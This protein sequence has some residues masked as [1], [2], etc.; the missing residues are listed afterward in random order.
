MA[1]RRSCA[2][3]WETA[4]VAL[5]ALLAPAR[6]KLTR[7]PPAELLRLR[8]PVKHD[9]AAR[10]GD[11]IAGASAAQV[12]A[13]TR[14]CNCEA[15]ACE[16]RG[17]L[18]AGLRGRH[19][20]ASAAHLFDRFAW[21]LTAA[22]AAARTDGSTLPSCATAAATPPTDASGPVPERRRLPAPPPRLFRPPVRRATDGM[23]AVSGEQGVP[24]LRSGGTVPTGANSDWPPAGHQA[25]SRTTHEGTE[26]QRSRSTAVSDWCSHGSGRSSPC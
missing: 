2:A 21:A 24:E 16:P 14:Q 13:G 1:S 7:R 12:W 23:R 9:T 15:T 18:T 5:P 10:A 8:C 17:G 11:C 26:L 3:A 25:Q 4:P 19:G 20:G 22:A 6:P